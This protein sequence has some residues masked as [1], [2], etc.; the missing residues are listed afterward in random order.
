VHEPAGLPMAVL[1]FTPIGLIAAFIISAIGMSIT[2]FTLHVRGLVGL[3]LG[4]EAA[5]TQ[6]TLGSLFMELGH[7]SEIASPAILFVYQFIFVV[8][9]CALPLAWLILILAVWLVP[10]AP[11]A[12]RSMLI[13]CEII[14]A[15]SML[16]VFAVILAASL[17]E[18]DQVAKF[19]LGSEC[20][21]LNQVLADYPSLEQ[22]LELPGE[23]SCFGVAPT[24]D[25]GWWL[26]VL[27][28]LLANICGQFVVCAAHTAVEEHA[29]KLRPAK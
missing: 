15:W 26:M 18:L 6:W 21:T 2:S 24:L 29:A 3:V 20:D 14:Y 12:L 19:T 7:V 10:F 27:G 16:D 28:V 4:P 22:Q 13:G 9:C 25:A 17:L 11:R 8:T 5:N 1:V 23:A